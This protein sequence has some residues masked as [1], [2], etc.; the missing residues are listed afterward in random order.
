MSTDRERRALGA[1]ES[2]DINGTEYKLR[3]IVAQH[4]ADLEKAALKYY[5]RNFLETYSDNLDL[6]EGDNTELMQTKLD[7]AARWDLKD[8]P[9]KAAFDVS[10]IPINDKVKAWIVEAFD[11]L[12]KKDKPKDDKAIRS[13]LAASLDSEK[14]KPSKL[15]ELSGK[16]P[17]EGRVRYD[18]WWITG[19]INGM[20][21]FIVTS[22]QY[23]HPEIR[24]ADVARWSFTQLAEASRKVES[25]TSASM[26]NG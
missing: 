11:E 19:S 8:L 3:P 17:L 24:T 13:L 5:K 26:G 22:L 16:A 18:Q 21:R 7:E 25:V 6:L 20:I 12:D 14:L 2:I 10:R 9:Y 4:L 1:C 23:D 15:K